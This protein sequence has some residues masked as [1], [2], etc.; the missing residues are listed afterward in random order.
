[1][2]ILCGGLGTRLRPAVA[3]RPK[4]LAEVAGRPFLAH[5]L[6]RLAEAGARDVVLSA[7]HRAGQVVEFARDG[8]PAGM[9]V[10]VVTEEVPLGTAGALRF[11]TDEASIS[12]PFVGLNG[13]TLFTGS[14]DRLLQEHRRRG[15]AATVALVHV[16]DAGRYGA[17]RFDAVT[18]DVVSFDEKGPSGPGWI[19]A[20]AYVLESDVLRDVPASGATSLE[21]DV[22]PRLVG[23]GLRAVPFPDATFLDIGTPEDYERAA[24]VLA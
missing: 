17:V 19:N 13:D 4:V 20:G 22:L 21:R 16:E 10:R 11:A 9:R 24:A 12:G 14:L 23:R 2:V 18:S 7:G 6:Q 3:D 5:L 1:M 15:D 8:A